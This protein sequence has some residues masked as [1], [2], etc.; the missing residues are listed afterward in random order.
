MKSIICTAGPGRYFSPIMATTHDGKLACGCD[1]RGDCTCRL[2]TRDAAKPKP[3]LDPLF[4][5][6][7]HR[8]LD[9]MSNRMGRIEQHVA[10]RKDLTEEGLTPAII[11]ANAAAKA[12]QLSAELYRDKI[13]NAVT[14]YRE[15]KAEQAN[16][17]DRGRDI[18]GGVISNEPP[19]D[20]RFRHMRLDTSSG[21][22]AQ[23][24]TEF[25]M[26]DSNFVTP[27]QAKQ[28]FEAHE[29]EQAA[30]HAAFMREASANKAFNDNQ[31][32]L[33][34]AMKD[35]IDGAVKERWK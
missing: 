25:P 21:Q 17:Q 5:A 24:S 23:K 10:H 1:A 19:P 13:E 35:Q 3:K 34:R 30:R 18:K 11:V 29:R 20:D 7:V 12:A 6:M 27:Q 32:A 4:L 26:G 14:E 16:P 2:S 9:F 28:M 31:H 33:V 8:A 22:H 15:K